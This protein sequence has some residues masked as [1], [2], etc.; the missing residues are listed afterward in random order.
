M[1]EKGELAAQ[2]LLALLSGA[3]QVDSQIL[4]WEVVI[5][6]TTSSVSPSPA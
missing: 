3:E 5:R 6:N 2:M 1:V 4:P